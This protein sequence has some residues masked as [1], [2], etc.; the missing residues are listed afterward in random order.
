MDARY[1]GVMGLFSLKYPRSLFLMPPVDIGIGSEELYEAHIKLIAPT[2]VHE[3]TH[4]KQY[5]QMGKMKYTLNAIPYLRE[6]LIEKEARA[7][8]RFAEIEIQE[9]K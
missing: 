3:L 9:L 1:N 6:V 5:R 4:M 2:I 7:N 8:E